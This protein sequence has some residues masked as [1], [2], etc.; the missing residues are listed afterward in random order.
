[1][2]CVCEHLRLQ[3]ELSQ[4]PAFNV[5]SRLILTVERGTARYNSH[6]ALCNIVQEA[7]AQTQDNT[8]HLS[9][10]KDGATK[11]L[12]GEEASVL[13]LHLHRKDVKAHKIHRYLPI[14]VDTSNP[15]TFAQLIPLSTHAHLL[16]KQP[17]GHARRLHPYYIDRECIKGW[18]RKCKSDHPACRLP[19]DGR[20]GLYKGPKRLVNVTKMCVQQAPYSTDDY[21]C[22]SYVWGDIQR[23]VLPYR[24]FEDTFRP[25]YLLS[26]QD[27]LHP[28]VRNAIQLTRELGE[29]YLWVD[30]LCIHQT[31]F[32][33]KLE[34]MS[35]MNDVFNGA[36]MTIVALDS[37]DADDTLHGVAAYATPRAVDVIEIDG[38]AMLRTDQYN[39]LLPYPRQRLLPWDGLVSQSKPGKAAQLILQK[40]FPP[41]ND[42]SDEGTSPYPWY[43][44]RWT[45]QEAM[46]SRRRLLL[47][48]EQAYFS[49][50]TSSEAEYLVADAKSTKNTVDF[51]LNAFSYY[52]TQ[53]MSKKSQAGF[54]QICGNLLAGLICAPIDAPK[55]LLKQYFRPATSEANSVSWETSCQTIESFSKRLSNFPE[56]RYLAF[57]GIENGQIRIWNLDL[58][59]GLP[60]KILP[61]ALLWRHEFDDAGDT[62]SRIPFYPSW[63]WIGWNGT[64]T[65]SRLRSLR[66]TIFE[67]KLRTI[68]I[69][70][71]NGPATSAVSLSF[72]RTG[73]QVSQQDKQ[74]ETGLSLDS[75]SLRLGK[76]RNSLYQPASRSGGTTMSPLRLSFRA[77]HVV[78]SPNGLGLDRKVTLKTNTG[79]TGNLQLSGPGS[80]SGYGDGIGLVLLGTSRRSRGR[81]YRTQYRPEGKESWIEKT[82]Y[83]LVL[84]LASTPLIVAAYFVGKSV[85]NHVVHHIETKYPGDDSKLGRDLPDMVGW[86]AGLALA[87]VLGLLVIQPTVDFLLSTPLANL[88]CVCAVGNGLYERVGIGEMSFREFKKL[89]PKKHQFVL[90]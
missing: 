80:F 11:D 84:L 25:G 21:L 87:F 45:M 88:I 1:M 82:L 58:V 23:R 81:L 40:V 76:L 35:E 63:S 64:V 72:D 56:D 3:K 60:V 18:L 24:K 62:V 31:D 19:T 71:A 4:A 46:F 13:G 14:A 47:T 20:R 86:L 85:K 49:C 29:T 83:L 52:T 7:F 9:I 65:F 16:G 44:R 15:R 36:T 67:L 57:K 77:Q 78:I 38:I 43:S 54:L 51:N 26:V 61:L 28:V 5:N 22:L 41:R 53:A 89:R 27:C 10:V 42:E 73:L 12:H 32:A 69:E 66:W 48:A 59:A 74:I 33:Q 6:C 90:I 55:F 50:Q 30:S 70:A 39:P 17:T 2:P 68:S 34:D 37:M 75:L 79:T 8:L